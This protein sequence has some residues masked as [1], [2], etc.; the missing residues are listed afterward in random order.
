[1]DSVSHYHALHL[2]QRL[3]RRTRH[4]GSA[5]HRSRD[6]PLT[7]LSNKCPIHGQDLHLLQAEEWECRGARV[8]AAV[9]GP[10]D[11]HFAYRAVS[12]GMGVAGE[13]TLDCHRH[14]QSY[15]V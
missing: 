10:W 6:R 11:D 3:S 13:S 8:Q 4:S 9:H 5:L 14:C 1:M 2:R 7:L 15:W 12:V